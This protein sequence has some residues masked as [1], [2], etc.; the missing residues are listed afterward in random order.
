MWTRWSACPASHRV[1]HF[2]C[3]KIWESVNL[4]LEH[5]GCKKWLLLDLL[6]MGQRSFPPWESYSF[7]RSWKIF[8]S[9]S[10]TRLV[11][12]E[13]LVLTLHLQKL[14]WTYDD[15]LW[16]AGTSFPVIKLEEL[17]APWSLMLQPPAR[18]K[19]RN[20][21]GAINENVCYKLIIL[22]CWNSD[23][24]STSIDFIVTERNEK[25]AVFIACFCLK[26]F[27]SVFR[28]RRCTCFV[29]NCLHC[30]RVFVEYMINL[31]FSRFAVAVATNVIQIPMFPCTTIT[32]FHHTHAQSDCSVSFFLSLSPYLPRIPR[33]C[34]ILPFSVFY[35]L[36]VRECILHIYWEVLR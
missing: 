35:V 3:N 13:C 15:H 23:L 19:R 29:M 30:V 26:G 20:R 22:R 18:E 33:K 27:S 28:S 11:E 4:R 31:F 25:W 7:E 14:L 6:D 2:V 16:V 9:K 5:I 32:F 8:S 12:V 10:P 34:L 17:I 21:N 36:Y 24:L 1:W